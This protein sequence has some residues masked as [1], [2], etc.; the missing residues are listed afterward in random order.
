MTFLAACVAFGT[1]MIDARAASSANTFF[2]C[3]T[4]FTFESSG[5]AARCRRGASVAIAPLTDCPPANGAAL[6]E[7]VDASGSKDMCG[8]PSPTGPDVSVDRSCPPAYT[9]R[10]LPGRD[11]C[12]LPTPEMIRAPSVPVAK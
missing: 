3:E 10:V 8:S 12:E 2:G 7:R 9:K 6:V 11:R 4:G 1:A 5:D